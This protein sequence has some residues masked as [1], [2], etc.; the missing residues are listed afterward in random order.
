MRSINKIT[1]VFLI[2]AGAAVAAVAQTP[3][4]YVAASGNDANPCSLSQPCRSVFHAIGAV[5]AG[6]EVLITEN[7]DYDTFY[8]AKA[9]TVSASPGIDAKITTTGGNAVWVGGVTTADTVTLRNLNMQGPGMLTT[10]FGVYNTT[11]G[12]LNI[13]N[14]RFTG[15]SNA[16]SSSSAATIFIRG[17]KILS[18]QFGIAIAT[19]AA[20]GV[21]KATID[22]CVIEI[23]ETG[24][25]LQAKVQAAILNTRVSAMA[26][27]ALH[28]RSNIAGMRIDVT[29]DNCQLTGNTVG[30]LTGAPQGNVAAR[31]SRTTIT[32]NAL[33]GIVINPGVIVYTLQNNTMINNGTDVLNGSMTPV[34]LK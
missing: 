13:E 22:N 24:I 6:G 2:I 14:C 31:I 23:G 7:G 28:F 3:R 20:E 8:V 5:D 33:Y 30:I 26:S 10:S 9:V 32:N 19:P 17:T 21:A 1:I 4:V 18:S 27:R 25:V 11:A 16:I 12:Q 34:G 15:F 29:V